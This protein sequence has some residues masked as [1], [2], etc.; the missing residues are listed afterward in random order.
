MTNTLRQLELQNLNHNI[1][2][3][4]EEIDVL[5]KDSVGNNIYVVDTIKRQ[6]DNTIASTFDVKDEQIFKTLPANQTLRL[7]DS[8]PKKAKALDITANRIIFGNYT[9]QF[10][11]PL[12]NPTFDVKLKNRY[13]AADSNRSQKQSIKSNRKYQIGVVFEDEYGRQSPVLTS[14]SGYNK[15][16]FHGGLLVQSIN[17]AAIL[18]VNDT[19]VGKKFNVKNMR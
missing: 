10:N 4:V 18:T 6:S 13:T 2:A 17:G 11:L 16:A 14:D 3:D 12:T 15:I 9:H 19:T 1:S 5:Y 7:F 8:V